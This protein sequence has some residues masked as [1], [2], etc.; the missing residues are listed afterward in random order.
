L[1]RLGVAGLIG[2]RMIRQSLPSDLIGG[3]ER[4]GDKI[5]RS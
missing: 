5:M 3:C 1:R 2:K 4:F